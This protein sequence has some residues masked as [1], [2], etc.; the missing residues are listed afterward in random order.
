MAE[1]PVFEL[2]ATSASQGVEPGDLATVTFRLVNS[3]E[4]SRSF[5]L[6]ASLP[7][8]W[9][10]LGKLAGPKLGA[11]SKKTLFLSFTVPDKAQA[12]DYTVELTASTAGKPSE[13][14]KA[15]TVVK[16][17]Q[18]TSLKVMA[19][20]KS[21]KASPG[22]RTSFELR[23]SNRGN[24]VDEYSVEL[25]SAEG[26][27]S[28]VEPET[29][30]LLP[31]R[32]GDVEI[33]V[34]V[35]PEATVGEETRLTVTVKSGVNR[36]TESQLGL[37]VKV[38]PPRP[39]EVPTQLYP[40]IPA[41]FSSKSTI[42]GDQS[43]NTFSLSA[44]G[45][46]TRD[47]RLQLDGR[48]ADFSTVKDFTISIVGEN[49]TVG[50]G[51]RNGHLV[52]DG[53]SLTTKFSPSSKSPSAPSGSLDLNWNP[54]K[55]ELAIGLGRADFRSEIQLL[56]QDGGGRTDSFLVSLE[57]GGGRQEG[58][59]LRGDYEFARGEEG[60]GRRYEANAGFSS[61]TG[62]VGLGASWYTENYPGGASDEINLSSNLLYSPP[63]SQF[64]TS[65]SGSFTMD[66]VTSERRGI[67]TSSTR[68]G[69][70]CDPPKAPNFAFSL[71]T[72]GTVG[73]TT[74]EQKLDERRT[75]YFVGLTGS[76]SE[77]NYE[78]SYGYRRSENRIS[79]KTYGREKISGGVEIKL[80]PVQ[81][82]FDLK[83]SKV[84]NLKTG[85]FKESDVGLGFLADF[86]GETSTHEL[87]ASFGRDSVNL[88]WQL[89][90]EEG[91][92]NSTGIDIAV[93]EDEFS[94]SLNLAGD[95]SLPVEPIKSKGQ[96]TG[97]VFVDENENGRPDT[98]EE[99]GSGLTLELGESLA[100]TN[101]EGEFVFPAKWPGE[102]EVDVDDLP[103]GF[104]VS[105]IPSAVKVQSGKTTEILIPLHRFSILSG[106]VFEDK[107]ENGVRDGEPGVGGVLVS[108]SGP[109]TKN[110]R[111]G[112]TGRFRS[113]LPA[114]KYRLQVED[115]SLPEG[116]EM[117]TDGVKEVQ[118]ESG[119]G[120]KVQFAIKESEKELLF[121]PT[122]KFSYS[123]ENPA[124]GDEV[125]FDA[126]A[127]QDF[128]GKIVN[129][130]WKTGDGR[131][132]QGKVVEH[133]YAEPGEYTV[134][135]VATD[136]DGQ[137]GQLEKTFVVDNENR[138]ND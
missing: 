31:G 47:H 116:Y 130:K 51:Y 124:A 69:F 52:L 129:Y 29:L 60:A 120:E 75:R 66:G 1:S 71:S 12:G 25:T 61:V 132:K 73:L 64:S 46:V 137:K 90:Q 6:A 76:A 79:G 134:T 4:E 110:L 99:G 80:D 48:V 97:R 24:V 34:K 113:R 36:E 50:F 20:E 87:G 8:G 21:R 127:S 81:L 58:P 27:D 43:S 57:S 107:N 44:D 86:T 101:E 78:L 106:I 17:S 128:D 65:L 10:T 125:T 33:Q 114:G 109:K 18:L 56:H 100:T 111:S 103:I 72:V 88:S 105:D 22:D 77:L 15:S 9:K 91:S 95:F 2:E 115:S 14:H 23:L 119:K 131:T 42:T 138:E 49:S 7:E 63:E 45:Y 53:I 122:A 3:S 102:Y 54:E 117:S 28:S 70:E 30:E 59:L 40:E 16:V 96:V 136:N 62:S 118:L 83:L 104:E 82:E 133:R 37:T 39:A 85:R 35:P 19:M 5:Q 13:E 68:F 74:R 55:K 38:I 11:G 26:W 41:E 89:T 92:L 112:P 98:G 123:P 67:E 135:L 93:G 94:G 126:S 108:V 84:R 121:A 32:S